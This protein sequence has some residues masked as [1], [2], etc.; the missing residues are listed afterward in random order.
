MEVLEKNIGHKLANE[1]ALEFLFGG[2]ALF[3]VKNN[4][5]GN[6]MVFK[7]VKSKK[8]DKEIYFVITNGEFL[9]SIFDRNKFVLSPKCKLSIDSPEV[10]AFAFIFD[11]LL[12][13][14]MPAKVEI[15]HSGRC[16]KC[17]RK[18]TDVQSIKLGIGPECL[19]RS[20]KSFPDK[21][22]EAV[23]GKRRMDDEY[24]RII[25]K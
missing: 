6:H 4:Q 2:N 14:S 24:D 10:K 5:S 7:V 21:Y 18:L 3:T 23:R 20:E 1:N 11:R 13:K 22:N 25:R 12:K 8:A 17:G 16:C 15:W 9:G 19:R